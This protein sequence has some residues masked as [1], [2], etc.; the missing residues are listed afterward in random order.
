MLGQLC[1]HSCSGYSDYSALI[2]R[3]FA[4]APRHQPFPEAVHLSCRYYLDTDDYCR[5]EGSTGLGYL[6]A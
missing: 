1:S 4:L 5:R 3:L 6:V 2:L